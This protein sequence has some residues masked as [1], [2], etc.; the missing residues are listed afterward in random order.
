LEGGFERKVKNR[1]LQNTWLFACLS[2]SLSSQFVVESPKEFAGLFDLCS[3]L[4]EFYSFFSEDEKVFASSER[5]SNGVPLERPNQNLFCRRIRRKEAHHHRVGSWFVFF[6]FP[7]LALVFE[8]ADI[9]LYLFA[10]TFE[11]N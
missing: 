1:T 11:C 7:S 4:C 6:V 3:R 10:K 2:W 5:P 9:S 8:V